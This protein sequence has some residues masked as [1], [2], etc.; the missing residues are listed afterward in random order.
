MPI[1]QLMVKN[2]EGEEVNDEKN[3]KKWEDF[4]PDE[5]WVNG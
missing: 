1:K 5:G 3:V 2:V 4:I